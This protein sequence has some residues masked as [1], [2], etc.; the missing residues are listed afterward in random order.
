MNEQVLKNHFED[1]PRMEPQDAVKLAYQSAF[2]CGHL[3]PAQDI[4]ARMIENEINATAEDEE[5]F[6]FTPIGNSI[7]VQ[8]VPVLLNGLISEKYIMV[9][10][11][12]TLQ[13]LGLEIRSSMRK[14]KLNI[15]R[16][17]GMLV[18]N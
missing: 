6:P 4:C 17:T 2:G 3:L 16:L 13:I 10:Q 8:C 12:K 9:V 11:L 5:A 7:L 15:P 18:F 14:N 1:A